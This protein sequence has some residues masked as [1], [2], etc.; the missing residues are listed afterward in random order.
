VHCVVT[1]VVKN[2]TKIKEARPGGGCLM[3][4]IQVFRRLRKEDCKVETSMSYVVR[5][6]QKT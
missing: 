4:V 6:F 2:K 1:C 5:L 3:P